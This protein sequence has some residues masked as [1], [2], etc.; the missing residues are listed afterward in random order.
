[1]TSTRLDSTSQIAK[2]GSST[3][4]R[5]CSARRLKRFVNTHRLINIGLQSGGAAEGTTAEPQ[6]TE[7]RMWLLAVFVRMPDLSWAFQQALGEAMDVNS[8]VRLWDLMTWWLDTVIPS[9]MAEIEKRFDP[10]REKDRLDRVR[11]ELVEVQAW[12][13]EQKPPWTAISATRVKKWIEP[14]S[15]YTFNL[16]RATTVTRTNARD[17]S[18]DGPT[19]ASLS[20]GQHVPSTSR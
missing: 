20:P 12:V 14:V 9:R 17:A 10:R 11:R 19:D 4:R 3:H 18:P 1:M 16:T 6:D 15:R 13:A 8:E 2:T 5:R 7:T